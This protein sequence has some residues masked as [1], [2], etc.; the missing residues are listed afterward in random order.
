MR[1]AKAW[2]WIAL[3]WGCGSRVPAGQDTPDASTP[4][5]DGQAGTTTGSGGQS[6]APGTTG[7][8]GIGAGG[9]G[10][11]GGNGGASGG[12]GGTTGGNGGAGR[13]GTGGGVT[14]GVGGASGAA[15]SSATGGAAG[16]KGGSAGAS[17]AS[18]GGMTGGAG[19]ASGSGGSAS[20]AAGAAGAGGSA[21]TGGA[22]DAGPPGACPAGSGSP[23]LG[24]WIGYIENYMTPQSGSDVVRISIRGADSSTLCGAIAFGNQ[25]AP[26]PPT[27]PNKN[28]PPDVNTINGVWNITPIDGFP[29]MIQSGVVAGKRVKFQATTREV[30]TAWCQLQTSYEWFTDNYRCLPNWGYGNAPPGTDD[31]GVDAGMQCGQT[32]PA[33]MQTV[34]R[35]C[36]QLSLCG[37]S[38]GGSVCDCNA[39]SCT[40]ELSATGDISFDA[41][42][43][44][45]EAKGT[46]RFP[47]SAQLYNVYLTKS[48]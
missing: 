43:D 29:H 15:G 12:T 48:E 1:N 24:S 4:R 37:V 26:P 30:W 6:G 45:A 42:F 34:R 31:S 46:I 10:A 33:T 40:V 28:Y 39:T 35:D 41:Q 25:A 17:G 7:T 16:S 36:G 38:S 47:Q 44:A 13:G 32:N 23:L 22:I 20:G 21:G 2:C 27:D 8:G 3:V 14:G 9:A 5:S 18:D 11:S 19:G